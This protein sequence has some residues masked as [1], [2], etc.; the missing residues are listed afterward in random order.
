MFLQE[1]AVETTKQTGARRK[2]PIG[3]R[4]RNRNACHSINTGH[5]QSVAKIGTESTKNRGAK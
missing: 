3:L 1:K 2:K 5:L 4:P